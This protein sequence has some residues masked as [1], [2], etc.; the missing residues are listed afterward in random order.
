MLINAWKWE[1][2]GNAF[3]LLTVGI[4]LCCP[5]R[6]RLRPCDAANGGGGRIDLF[7]PL[8][9]ATDAMPCSEWEMDYV[10]ADGPV[11]LRQR[12]PR[13]LCVFAWSRVDAPIGGLH[14]CDGAIQWLGMKFMQSPVL[15]CDPLLRPRPPLK[16]PH[17]S[18]RS[19]HHL[20]WWKMQLRAM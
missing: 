11:I 10:N 9:N 15:N 17:L 14:A 6:R 4:G 1:G 7:Q 12:K 19:P 18:I 2:T 16:G 8:N 13:A 3:I 20:I 5:M